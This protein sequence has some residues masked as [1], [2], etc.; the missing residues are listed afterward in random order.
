MGA[1][2]D[3]GFPFP[4]IWD[5]ISDFINAH[6]PRLTCAFFRFF[7]VCF[8]VITMFS[9]WAKINCVVWNGRLPHFYISFFIDW[10]I[11]LEVLQEISQSAAFLLYSRFLSLVETVWFEFWIKNLPTPLVSMSELFFHSSFVISRFGSHCLVPVTSCSHKLDSI[12]YNRSI[13][14]RI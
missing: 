2:V 11:F 12:Y 9:L 5:N 4:L 13:M 3:D 8:L 1:E 14:R 6:Y 10:F 7:F